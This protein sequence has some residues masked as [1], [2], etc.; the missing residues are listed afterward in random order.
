M[1]LQFQYWRVTGH[2]LLWTS[3][4]CSFLCVLRLLYNSA[5]HT[6]VP[7]ILVAS[8]G[9]PSLRACSR[10]QFRLREPQRRQCSRVSK[11]INLT[12]TTKLLPALCCFC[13]P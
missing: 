6:L 1:L 7:V 13:T 10:S 8:Q 2:K 4:K 9:R 12:S 11:H 5:L 3:K